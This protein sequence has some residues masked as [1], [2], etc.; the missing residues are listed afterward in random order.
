MKSRSVE[1]LAGQRVL[2]T[3]GAGFIGSHIVEQLVEASAIVRVLDNFETGRPENLSHVARHVEIVQGDV[4]RLEDCM[5][6]VEGVSFISHQAAYCSAPG[7]LVEPAKCIDTNVTGLTNLLVAAREAKVRRVV[8]ASSSSV[9][10][11]GEDAA[12]MEPSRGLPSSPYA[13][14]KAM[15]EQVAELFSRTYGM[16]I[17]GLRYFNVYG[18]R[19]HG[20]SSYAAV[21]PR[22]FGACEGGPGPVV[23]GDGEQTR[24]FVYVGDIAAA[25]VFAM[26]NPNPLPDVINVGTGRGTKVNELARRIA[27]NL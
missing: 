12:R 16:T 5:R 24:D 27:R 8:Y 10:G 3:G 18:P 22:F 13:L 17:V 20:D 19:Q 14:S 11:D 21:I 7:S 25:N 2:V 4:R 6:A 1:V 23:H 9:Y 26:T 15:G